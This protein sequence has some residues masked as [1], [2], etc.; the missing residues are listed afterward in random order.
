MKKRTLL[1]TVILILC[2]AGT[3][4]ATSSTS[5]FTADEFTMD[6][7]EAMTQGDNAY[8]TSML[9]E[10]VEAY[11]EELAAKGRTAPAYLWQ[12]DWMQMMEKESLLAELDAVK[13]ADDLIKFLD[14]EDVLE[15]EEPPAAVREAAEKSLAQAGLEMLPMA[16]YTQAESERVNG[17]MTWQVLCCGARPEDPND[18]MAHQLLLID[19]VDGEQ[20]LSKLSTGVMFAPEEVREATEQEMED[21]IARAQAYVGGEM[22]IAGGSE[23]PRSSTKVYVNITGEPFVFVM[24]PNNTAELLGDTQHAYGNMVA[25]GVETGSIYEATAEMEADHMKE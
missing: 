11:R 5:V 13:S 22:K 1:M 17:A 15:G 24:V 3:A 2:L 4:F 25:V 19:E 7:I 8:L 23:A 18:L 16:V 14:R 21:A 20:V 10:K 12:L 6:S 9:N